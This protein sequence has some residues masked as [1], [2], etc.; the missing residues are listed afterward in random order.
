MPDGMLGS[1]GGGKLIGETGYQRINERRSKLDQ[2]ALNLYD[3]REIGGRVE[4]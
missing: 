1:A 2:L 3:E 4:G